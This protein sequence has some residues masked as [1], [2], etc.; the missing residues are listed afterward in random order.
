M[1]ALSASVFIAGMAMAADTYTVDPAHS[2]ASFKIRHLGVSTTTGRFNDLSGTVVLD[3]AD[4]SKN[5]VEIEIKTASVDTGNGPRDTHLKKADFFD[6]EKYPTMT[7]KSTSFKKKGG[8]TYEIKGDF[9]LHGVTKNIAI[10]AEQTGTG[11]DREGKDL[12]GF[13]TEFKIVRSE[14]GMTYGTPAIGDEVK[15]SFSAECAKKA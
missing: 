14:Y 12:I 7:F 1:F 3:V 4:E 2:S 8:T 10:M 15:I 9:T 11:K 13:E 6:V 5:K